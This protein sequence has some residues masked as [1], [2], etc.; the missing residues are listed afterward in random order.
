MMMASK[1]EIEIR[2]ACDATSIPSPACPLPGVVHLW[3]RSLHASAAEVGSCYGLLSNEEK[4]R[5]LRFRIERPRQDFV[6]TRGALRCLLAR[7]LGSTPQQVRLG[8]A[9]KGKPFLE[10]DNDLCFNVSHTDGLALLA[11][12]RG[13]A[14]GVDIE[15][16]SRK[17]E[18]EQLAERFFSKRERDDLK[19]LHGDELRAAFFRCWTRKEAYIKARGEGLSLPLDHFDVSVAKDECR[20]LA[21]RPDP[22]EA[23][24]WTLCDLAVRD[25]YTAALALAKTTQG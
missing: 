23:G 4:E 17:V 7:Y 9:A 16:Q 8:N 1:P 18:A 13:R 20:L 6:L 25:G 11:F 12:V 5:A 19:H 22:S 3:R 21:T 2:D 14:I 24:R 15:Q 10:G